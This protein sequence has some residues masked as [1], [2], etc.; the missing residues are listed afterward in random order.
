MSL[1][2]G[3]GMKIPHALGQLSPW[4]TTTEPVHHTRG[5]PMGHNGDLILPNK[6]LKNNGRERIAMINKEDEIRIRKK[7]GQVIFC[8][9]NGYQISE[10]LKNIIMRTYIY[11]QMMSIYTWIIVQKM[12]KI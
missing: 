2:P 4:A 6:H 7:I 10:N 9:F 5:K 12:Q 8:G 11:I 3:Q 1:T